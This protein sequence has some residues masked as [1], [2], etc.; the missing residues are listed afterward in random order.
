MDGCSFSERWTIGLL[1]PWRRRRWR[2]IIAYLHINHIHCWQTGSGS[3][4]IEVIVQL[5]V[6]PVSVV[7]QLCQEFAPLSLASAIDPTPQYQTHKEH[8][9]KKETNEILVLMLDWNVGIRNVDVWLGSRVRCAA[10]NCCVL[11]GYQRWCGLCGQTCIWDWLWLWWW[12]GAVILVWI[13]TARCNLV[14]SKV[15]VDADVRDQA[16]E[17][18][19]LT[20]IWNKR[21]WII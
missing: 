11:I 7:I 13:V 17:F 9:E 19:A 20:L 14:A 2:A 6:L 10:D 16:F 3:H 12:S 5:F 15:L 4:W 21:I 1:L 8:Y 18:G